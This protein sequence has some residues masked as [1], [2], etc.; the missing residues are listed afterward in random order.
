[1][2]SFTFC[3][4]H[5]TTPPLL[6]AHALQDGAWRVGKRLLE[7]CR[8]MAPGKLMGLRNTVPTCHQQSPVWGRRVVEQATQRTLVVLY[9][10]MEKMLFSSAK[11]SVR[12]AS[13]MASKYKCISPGKTGN[14]AAETF[15]ISKSKWKT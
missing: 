8:V 5:C 4:I 3:K 15:H 9:K 2:F 1:M 7:N 11:V 12:S 14:E 10:G 13:R 6:Q